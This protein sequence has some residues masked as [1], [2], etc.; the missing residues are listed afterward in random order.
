MSL[1]GAGT[2]DLVQNG[3]R[4]I[5]RALLPATAFLL[6]I[7]YLSLNGLLTQPFVHAASFVSLI[8]VQWIQ[9]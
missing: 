8:R 5:S 9:V 7:H 3:A 6:Q 1:G 2:Q 4:L